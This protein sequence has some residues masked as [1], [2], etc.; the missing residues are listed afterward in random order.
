[1]LSTEQA[2]WDAYYR[3]ESLPTQYPTDPDQQA[4]FQ[5]WYQAQKH[6]RITAHEEA[7][8]YHLLTIRDAT[9][10]RKWAEML[11]NNK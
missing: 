9:I 3:G 11:L 1:M 10:D 7:I 6:N 4:Y 8:A 2:G 5:G